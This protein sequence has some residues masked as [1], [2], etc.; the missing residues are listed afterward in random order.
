MGIWH[1]PLALPAKPKSLS[2]TFSGGFN[3]KQFMCEILPAGTIVSMMEL[4]KA[5]RTAGIILRRFSH[6]AN[7]YKWFDTQDGSLFKQ[8]LRLV[9]CDG[10]RKMYRKGKTRLERPRLITRLPATRNLLLHLVGRK[11][12]NTYTVLHHNQSAGTLLVQTWTIIHPYNA[13]QKIKLSRLDFTAPKSDEHVATVVT[14]LQRYCGESGKTSDIFEAGLTALGLPLP[15]APP[16]PEFTVIPGD[17]ILQVGRKILRRQAYKM[18][19]NTQG[20]LLALDPEYLHDLRVATRR[21]RFALKLLEAHIDRDNCERLRNELRWI[22]SI[23]GSVRDLDVFIDR[24]EHQLR[25]TAAEESVCRTIIAMLSE[26][27]VP[28]Q[29]QLAAALQTARYRSLVKDLQAC[30]PE[31]AAEDAR[32]AQEIA[33]PV[34]MKAVAKLKRWQKYKAE[35]FTPER[36]HRLRIRFKQLR[37]TCEFFDGIYEGQMQKAINMCV[38]FQDCLGTHQDACVAIRR[39]MT[40]AG[41]LA[42]DTHRSLPRILTLGELIQIQRRIMREQYSQFISL[43]NVFPKKV[44]KLAAIINN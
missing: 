25:E 29:E 7:N 28:E 31:E 14:A 8:S 35:D 33:P 19:G 44:K 34:I 10:T 6:S 17:T 18:W 42:A 27:R 13:A 41:P 4:R 2:A 12:E 15:G 20:T 9:E 23:L 16:L 39:L 37:Y 40:M 32:P 3:M 21:A 26:Q 36:L 11:I 5:L 1:N 22:A 43:W 24:L 30:I 38:T